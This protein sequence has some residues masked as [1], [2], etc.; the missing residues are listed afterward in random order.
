MHAAAD[1]LVVE[2]L[3]YHYGARAAVRSASLGCRRGEILG[4]LGPNGAGKTT[5]LSCIAG[6]LGGFRGALR[7]DGR[8][9][10]PSRDAAARAHLGLVPQELAL[11]DDL[12]ARENLR[13]FARMQGVP[14]AQ[15]DAAIDRALALAGLQDRADD[16]VATYS[17]GMKRR[18]NLAIGDLHEPELL[19]LDE[20]TTG[21]D[22]QSRNHLFECL[23]ALR[24]QGRT[25]L[26][27]SHYMEEVQ[28]L[29]DRIVVLNEGVVVGAGTA[30]ELATQAGLP[31]AD[32]E[33][34]FL[35]MTGRSLRDDA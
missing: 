34:V 31:G 33:Q 22:P 9:F 10:V 25:L 2:D 4:V 11:Y 18:L 24:T 27:T 17:G 12:T 26:Y 5:L 29:C 3:S 16:R 23:L 35:A 32:L 21:V 20:P 8:P 13:F 7:F 30:A 19:L 28:R 6:L 15:V 1:L 14:A